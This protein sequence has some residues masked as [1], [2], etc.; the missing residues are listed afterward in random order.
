MKIL[1]AVKRV[2]D[3]NLKA[4]VKS[5]GGGVDLSNQK[6]SMNPFDEIAVEEAVRLKEAGKATEIIVVSIGPTLATEQIRQAL[7]LGA[8]RGILIE[9]DPDIETLDV[10][11]L[12]AEVSKKETCDLIIMGKQ[13]IDNDCNQAGQ[14]TASLLGWAQ[15]TFISALTI[16]GTSLTF[17]R[18]VDGG[19]ETLKC[20]LPA[21]ITTDL[22]L[23]E[24]RYPKLPN[25][26]KAKQ[27]PLE[28][29]TPADFGITPKMRHEILET[30][31]PPVRK[32]GIKV[33]SVTD[34]VQKLHLEAGVL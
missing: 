30:L 19:L 15:G 18:E 1:V 11:K 16:D 13:A 34:L 22:R 6:M 12:I 33:A 24:P 20:T 2:L 7:A 27:K 31:E 29:F 5:D 28:T 10:A 23:N 4:R 21:V 9:S 14:M 25:I 17:T 8:D 3:Y 32:G 26:M